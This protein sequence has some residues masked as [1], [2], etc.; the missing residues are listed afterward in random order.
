[1]TLVRVRVRDCACPDTPHAEEGDAIFLSPT[2][3]ALGGIVAEQQMTAATDQEKLVQD[4]LVTFVRYGAKDWNLPEP[5]DVEAILNDYALFRPVALEAADL[6]QEAVTAPLAPRRSK[7]SPTG[8]TTGTTSRR[9][10]PT[11][12][13]SA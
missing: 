6:Y 8:P 10:A 13:P 1:M 4:W 12:A 2:L 3:P 11:P 7:P 5:F 9:R